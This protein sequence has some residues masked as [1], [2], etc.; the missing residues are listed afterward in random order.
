MQTLSHLQRARQTVHL[1]KWFKHAT[2]ALGMIWAS[3]DISMIMNADSDTRK[4]RKRIFVRALQAR[5]WN[6]LGE[7][8]VSLH[9]LHPH[10]QLVKA[11]DGGIT[12]WVWPSWEFPP[13]T[14]D[15]GTGCNFSAP[16]EE[17]TR[18][19]GRQGF[20]VDFGTE[21]CGYKAWLC[22]GS[23]ALWAPSHIFFSLVSPSFFIWV[24]LC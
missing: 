24:G 20:A 15:T 10:V 17:E 3:A 12:L 18:E 4:S 13:E 1:T 16:G 11:R 14:P 21:Q 5:S 22:F 19:T 2:V 9:L 7:W 8:E 23:G 6:M